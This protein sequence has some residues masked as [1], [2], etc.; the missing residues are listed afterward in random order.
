MIGGFI[1]GNGLGSNGDGSSTVLVRALGPE[2]TGFGI[3]DA[4]LDAT[5]DLVDSNGNLVGSN[6][7][8]KDSQQTAIQATGLRPGRRSRA[9]HFDHTYSGELDSDC[10]RQK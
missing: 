4:L 7:N 1:V 5:L 2:L 9:S 10:A 3:A 8:W 6:D